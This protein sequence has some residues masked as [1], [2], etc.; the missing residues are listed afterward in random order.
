M[1][2]GCMVAVE[3]RGGNGSNTENLHAVPVVCNTESGSEKQ[4]SPALSRERKMASIQRVVGVNPI[5]NADAIEASKIL[6]WTV[7][8]KKGEFKVGDLCVYVEIDALLP[9]RPEFEF[10]RS[11]KFRIKTVRLRGQVSQ[12]IAFPLSILGG[13]EEKPEG[14][15]LFEGVDVSEILGI[16]KYEPPVDAAIGGEIS[17]P[18]P[19]FLLKT[20]EPR[21]QSI[22]GVLERHAG[23]IGYVAEKLEG[24]SGT[25]YVK[26]GVFGVCSRNFELRED[27]Q[28]IF[29]LVARKLN[30]EE[31]LLSLGGDFAVQ[32]EV[33]GPKI[34]GNLYR[35]KEPAVRFF[36]LFDIENSEYLSFCEF[37][38]IVSER[39]G[40]PLVPILDENYPLPSCVDE[41]I[42]YAEGKSAL[43]G[44]SDV[45]REGIVWRPLEE[46][47]DPDIGR[48]SVKAV[49]N[50]YLLKQGK[51]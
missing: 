34:Q 51:D 38:K 16:V 6:G 39:L 21:I 13:V 49:S 42:G 1:T 48:L 27:H 23:K 18:M 15:E 5:Q 17:R 24:A 3:N 8:T 45:E 32:G 9:E 25:F 2:K 44:C 36:N 47:R 40:L 20:D 12:G 4:H 41:L 7:V 50:R 28:N 26:N 10:M 46:T 37:K 35:L 43:E 19:G 31:K 33:I 30:L 29:W 14:L 22:P 11:K